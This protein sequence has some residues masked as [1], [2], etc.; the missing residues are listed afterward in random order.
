MNRK[1]D[2]G[3][4]LKCISN[5]FF[6][7]IYSSFFEFK[8]FLC[9]V[10]AP[11]RRGLAA[12]MYSVLHS[13]GFCL[14]LVLGAVLHW[15]LA[16]AVP[17]I[18]TLPTMAALANLRESPSWLQR[19]GRNKEAQEA[20]AFYRI[21][22]PAVILEGSS[23][24]DVKET[25]KGLLERLK[26]ILHTLTL[27]GSAFWCNFAFLATLFLLLGW[28]GFSILSFYAVEVFQL[29]GSPISAAHT[30]WITR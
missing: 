7:R 25:K 18:L 14:M 10:V 28:C 23:C 22:L 8:V 6:K 3:L 5:D 20:A 1:C 15:R 17:A 29:S 16:M 19:Q 30:S 24:E 13:F 4:K 12:A 27:Q 11:S 9:E 2:L 26:A 21:S